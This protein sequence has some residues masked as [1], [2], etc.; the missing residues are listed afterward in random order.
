MKPVRL[1]RLVG[2]IAASNLEELHLPYRLTYAVTSRCQARCTMC[3]IWQKSSQDE[4]SLAEI[5][6]LFAHANRLSWINLTGGEIFQRDDITDIIL[7]VVRQSRDLYLLNFPTNG[8]QTD[9]IISTV[10]RVLSDT[11]LPRLIVSVSMDGPPDLHDTIRG[12]PGSWEHAIETY[13]QLRKCCSGRFAVYLGHTVQTANIG[14]FFETVAASKEVVA[15]LTVDDFHVNLAHFSGHYYDN[16]D[17][18]AFPDPDRAAA[19]LETIA[20]QRRNK[21][22]DPVSYIEHRYQRHLPTY[23]S[24]H[25][26]PLTCQAAAASC[27]ID[28]TGTVYPCSVYDAP[29]GALR[30]YGMDLHRL[31]QSTERTQIRGRICRAACPGC[32]TPCE[33]YQTLLANLLRH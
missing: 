3:N 14:R 31:W 8:F 24:S 11:R 2:R 22:F 26:V 5:D 16:A 28:P 32:W 21:P 13:R 12:L 30:D 29:I 10:D 7:S 1:A 4:L 20:T 9:E 19:E 27:F 18:N 33:A 25:R 23:L 6:S 15:N 17:K